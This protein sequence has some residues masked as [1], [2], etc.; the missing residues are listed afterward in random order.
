MLKVTLDH[1]IFVWPSSR[2]F[3]A[4]VS[5]SP[6]NPF[7]HVSKLKRNL[8]CRPYS[9]A[10]THSH[11]KGTSDAPLSSLFAGFMMVPWLVCG[12]R[13]DESLSKFGRA[14]A[15]S[16]SSRLLVSFSLLKA[17]LLVLSSSQKSDA[18]ILLHVHGSKEGGLQVGYLMAFFRGRGCMVEG[19]FGHASGG[20]KW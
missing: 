4:P 5:W 14:F 18:P 2:K 17:K 3:G 10:K 6:S 11:A 7:S 1:L 12:T 13:M 9:H 15:K 16:S 8:P 20:E 19:L